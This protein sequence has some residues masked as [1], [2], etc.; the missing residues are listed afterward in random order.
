MTCCAANRQNKQAYDNDTKVGRGLGVL[1]DWARPHLRPVRPELPAQHRVVAAGDVLV[2]E[3]AR[4]GL[5][6]AVALEALLQQDLLE[7]LVVQRVAVA[8]RAVDVKKYA[9]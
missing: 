6:A 2:K 3:L 7:C 8:E 1:A 9:A 5:T 4:Y